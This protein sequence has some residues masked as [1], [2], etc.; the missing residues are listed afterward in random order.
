MKVLSVAVH[1]DDETLGCGGTL[2]KHQFNGDEIYCI[3]MTNNSK[4]H[5]ETQAAIEDSYHFNKCF[6]LNCPVMGIE[7]I[8]LNEIVPKLS[9]IINRIKPDVLYI[10]NRSD[11]HSDHRRVFEAMMVVTKSFR[12]PFI[13]KIL[14]CEVLSSTES[15]PALPETIFIPNVYNDISDFLQKKLSIMKLYK[16]EYMPAPLPRSVVTIEALARYRGSRI[17]TE[18]AEAFMLLFEKV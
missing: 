17:G 8:S 9:G 1:P 16:N 15:A 14:M 10:P 6:Y 2:L 5:K 4:D 11:I 3:F 7:D 18:F 13:K 12:Y